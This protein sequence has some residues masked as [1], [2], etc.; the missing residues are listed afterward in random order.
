M[1]L[2]L[3]DQEAQVVQQKRKNVD[4]LPTYFN[5]DLQTNV[6]ISRDFEAFL[7]LAPDDLKTS[8]INW[9]KQATDLQKTNKDRDALSDL[10]IAQE[11]LN[12]TNKMNALDAVLGDFNDFRSS[13]Q[14]DSTFADIPE[15]QQFLFDLQRVIEELVNSRDRAQ[16]DSVA[17][18]VIQRGDDRLVITNPE[19]QELQSWT[20]VLSQYL[21]G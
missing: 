5:A 12:A 9:I 2:T 10:A 7:I 21:A 18:Q 16:F 11:I 15:V 6:Q 1:A 17:S 8:A 13:F 20:G 3:T 4:D 14:T 19:I